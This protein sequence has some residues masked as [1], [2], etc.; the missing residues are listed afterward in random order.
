MPLSQSIIL[1]IRVREPRE[2][3][4]DGEQIADYPNGNTAR[5]P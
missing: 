4:E 3:I 5:V 1:S 2:A